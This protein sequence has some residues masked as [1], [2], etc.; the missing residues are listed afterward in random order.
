MQQVHLIYF[1]AESPFNLILGLPFKLTFL[2]FFAKA[3]NSIQ[4]T[5]I[6]YDVGQ[7][8]RDGMKKI[9]VTTY[10]RYKSQGLKEGQELEQGN[11]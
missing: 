7:G 5:K 4:L 2:I 9:N 6:R 1:G 11:R 8:K 10:W 3:T